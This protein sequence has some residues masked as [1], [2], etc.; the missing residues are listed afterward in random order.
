MKMNEVGC[1]II[2]IL[3]IAEWTE[4]LFEVSS[5]NGKPDSFNVTLVSEDEKV[6]A[7]KVI[8]SVWS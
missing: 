1:C 7:N 5:L 2:D 8:S 4:I 3:R 6:L